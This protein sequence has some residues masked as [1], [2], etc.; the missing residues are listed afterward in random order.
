MLIIIAQT[1]RTWCKYREMSNI[2]FFTLGSVEAVRPVFLIVMGIFLM[3]IAWRLAK[4]SGTWT[5]RIMVAGA[6][7]LGFGYAVLLPLY[8]AGLIEK[9]SP[10]G[11]FHG[12]MATALAWHLTKM[13]VMN[14]GWF[15]F[16]IGLAMHAK[17]LTSPSPRPRAETRV[18]SPH[19]SV[20]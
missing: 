11:H 5:S 13:S 4:T 6:L 12:N 7:L 2:G 1:V 17:I 16:G 19:E 15:L 8:E 20:A 3:L 18:N 9:F 14:A 10:N